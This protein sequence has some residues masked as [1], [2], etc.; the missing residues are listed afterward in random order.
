MKLKFK[1]QACQTRA[2]QAVVDCFEGQ[3][4]TTGISYRLDPGILKQQKIDAE[5]GQ[6]RIS[7]SDILESGFKNDEIYLNE[8]QLL[9]NIQEVQK[10]DNLPLNQSVKEFKRLKK[11]KYQFDSNYTQKALDIAPF[12]LDIEMETGTGKTYCYTK[13]IFE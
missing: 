12:N 6:A 4:N 5:F 7:Y 13:T 9:K 8:S 2:V 11:N 10:G 1:I 3:P